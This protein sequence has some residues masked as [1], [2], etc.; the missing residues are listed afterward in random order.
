MTTHMTL[1][2]VLRRGGAPVCRALATGLLVAAL[3]GSTGCSWFS[4]GKKIEADAS[5]T[6]H[7]PPT[8][9]V[10]GEDM[11]KP[12]SAPMEIPRPFGLTDADE[13]LTRIYFDYDQA[14]I[15]QDQIDQIEK[16]LK[17][18]LANADLR[19][20]IE[21]HCDERGSTEYN[22]ALGDRRATA[23]MDYLIRGGIEPGRITTLSKGEEEP[24]EQGGDEAA[25]SKNRR[26]QFK[27]I[28]SDLP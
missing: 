5:K 6:T 1:R 12:A 3:L 7:T 17:Y 22:F 20:L 15:R 9:E 11:P 4:R 8:G 28:N 14:A 27:F 19:V 2:N 13:F 24:A 26:C 25:W 23:V 18:L 16:N 10:T 21:G